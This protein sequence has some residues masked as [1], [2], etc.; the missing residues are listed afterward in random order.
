MT[1]ILSAYDNYYIC[2]HSNNSKK[3]REAQEDYKYALLFIT[4]LVI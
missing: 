4:K 3:T 2:I 1:F